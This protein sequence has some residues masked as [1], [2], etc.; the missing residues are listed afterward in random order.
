MKKKFHHP[1]IFKRFL[2]KSNYKEDEKIVNKEELT[3]RRKIIGE[4]LFI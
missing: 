3:L 4:I 1:N 2:K